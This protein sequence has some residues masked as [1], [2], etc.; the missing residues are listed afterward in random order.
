M[1][2]I[3][4]EYKKKN[5]F[6]NVLQRY[7]LFSHRRITCPLYE[8]PALFSVQVMFKMYLILPVSVISEPLLTTSTLR[9]SHTPL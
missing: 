3:T 7:L 4:A 8:A 6:E 5:T 1:Q 9:S 2:S